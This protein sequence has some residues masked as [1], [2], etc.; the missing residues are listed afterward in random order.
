MTAHVYWRINVSAN[1][2]DASFLAIAEVEMRA[3]VGGADQCA[4]GTGLASASFSASFDGPKAFDNSAATYWATPS[5]TL[6]GW[7]RY[8]F[9]SAVEVAEY[10]IQA[11]PSAPSRSPS[12]WALEWSDDGS[13]WTPLETRSGFTSWTNGQIRTFAVPTGA[14]Q[15][16]ASQLPLEVLRTNLAPQAHASQ[17][18]LEV[19]RTNTPPYARASQLAL[20]VLRPNAAESGGG[21][22]AAARPMVF[23]AT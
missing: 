9:A 20:E 19:L 22:G 17:L 23:F 14:M 8:Q 5:G 12:A 10:T 2:G 1:A 6:S 21:G 4:G 13:A 16:R 11:H 3:T 7:L 18:A 15:V